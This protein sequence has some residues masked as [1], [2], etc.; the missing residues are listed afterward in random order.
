MSGGA[1]LE[2]SLGVLRQA[3]ARGDPWLKEIVGSRDEVLSRFQPVFS[4][5]HIPDLTEDEFRSFLLFSNN[6]HWPLHR[7]WRKMCS[8]MPRLRD[9]LSVL[10][11][12]S[13][14]IQE[15]MDYAVAVPG[16]GRGVMTAVLLVA[17]PEKYGVWN[18]TSEQALK[19]LELW[20]HF[21]WGEPFG[22][23]YVKVNAVLADLARALDVDLWT[24]DAAFWGVTDQAPPERGDS[25]SGAG[26]T[27]ALAT[28]TG[29]EQR[30]AL[31]RHL[32]E[33]LRDNWDRTSLGREW[34]LYAEPGND[35]AG[36]EYP[37][38]VG[39]IDLLAKHRTRPAWLVVELKRGQGSDQTAGQV[40]RY[41][42]WV[43]QHL[44]Q[45]EE[46]VAGLVIAHE[47]DDS[48][49]YALAAIPG[50]ALM[51][52]DVQFSLREPPKLGEEEQV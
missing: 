42:G 6:H 11:D 24:L 1:L 3:L 27:E 40:A 5:E 26:E 36:Y 49:R 50:V 7:Q 52:Y 22:S 32:H 43:R 20:P 28:A 17:Y 14:L 47:T 35:E 19:A 12:E 48:L 9:A 23:R 44:A 39:R 2:Q 46:E 33:F 51:L 13:R 8:D 25:E 37:C 4:G 15:R 16:M 29:T 18:N 10:L 31:E 21:D 30:F 41:M 38:G 34:A 45:P